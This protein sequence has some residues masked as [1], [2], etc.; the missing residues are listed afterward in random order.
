MDTESVTLEGSELAFQD[1]ACLDEF[2]RD[3]RHLCTVCLL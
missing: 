1:E 2:A 3:V